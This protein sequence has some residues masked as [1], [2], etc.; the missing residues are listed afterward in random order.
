[1][2]KEKAGP[3]YDAEFT[4]GS[5]WF[6]YTRRISTLLCTCPRLWP[7]VGKG[8][9]RVDWGGRDPGACPSHDPRPAEAHACTWTLTHI[10]V[11]T[12]ISL[13]FLIT[14]FFLAPSCS[15]T[16]LSSSPFPFY[17]FSSWTFSFWVTFN[18]CPILP[19]S[20]WHLFSLWRHFPPQ[21]SPCPCKYLYI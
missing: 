2:L 4:A 16:P 18:L 6:K 12:L 8:V 17:Y 11:H 3:N 21:P 5:G 1:M 20:S 14:S 10:H 13:P 7:W 9:G 15:L 19:P